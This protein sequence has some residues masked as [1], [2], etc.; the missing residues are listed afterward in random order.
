MPG[1]GSDRDVDFFLVEIGDLC[2]HGVERA[3]LLAD[4]D[5]LNHHGRHEAGLHERGRHVL[6]FRDD[7][8][9]RT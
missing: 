8:R 9:A 3:G 6:A 4:A 5:H 7:V 2:Q 1:H